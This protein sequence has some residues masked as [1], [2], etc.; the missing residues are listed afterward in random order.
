M[1]GLSCS[2]QIF[3]LH[4]GYRAFSCSMQDLFAA[5]QLLVVAC[6]I[7]FP[8]C[9]H[10]KLLQSCPTL[11]DP[12]YYSLPGSS[13]REILQARILEWVAVSLFRGSSQPRNQ[14]SFSCVPC[15]GRRVL[16]H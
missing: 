7:K 15:V 13:V 11:C 3:D 6:G 12:I 4:C 10:A 9:V 16:Y 14:T 2:S 5:C 1:E 8:V